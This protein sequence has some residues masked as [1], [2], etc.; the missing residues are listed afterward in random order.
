MNALVSSLVLSEGGCFRCALRFSG[1]VSIQSYLSAQA[2]SHQNHC[3]LCLGILN[4]SKLLCAVLEKVNQSGY[5][6][7]DYKFQVTLPPIVYL[8]QEWIY[9]KCKLSGI[10]LDRVIDIKDAFKWVFSPSIGQQI[11]KAFS[12][13]SDFRVNIDFSSPESQS[14]I[15]EFYTQF[16][17][18]K[19]ES[20]QTI[21]KS[22]NPERLVSTF[23]V[24]KPFNYNMQL[25][26]SHGPIY[27]YGHYLKLA[28]NISQTPWNIDGDN[29]ITD[30]VQ[31]AISRVL[32]NTFQGSAGILHSSVIS[33]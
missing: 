17:C 31:D 15:D 19:K 21:F 26:V 22:V 14:E 3:S 16:K 5:E 10:S 23:P 7:S 2:E 13:N 28:R 27:I 6:H 12:V 33:N 18:S 9:G 29:E 1:D 8:R 30:S 20:L 24:L 11:N 4:P 25:G 32:T